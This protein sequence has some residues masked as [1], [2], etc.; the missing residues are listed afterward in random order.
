MNADRTSQPEPSENK[1]AET[2]GPVRLSSRMTSRAKQLYLFGDREQTVRVSVKLDVA[3]RTGKLQGF[4]AELEGSV[5]AGTDD[6]IAI[7]VPRR[8]L[9]DLCRVPGVLQVDAGGSYAIHKDGM[10]TV[11]P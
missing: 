7:E 8:S 2:A 1:L 6:L 10:P 5:I 9:D 11:R 4:V 3:K